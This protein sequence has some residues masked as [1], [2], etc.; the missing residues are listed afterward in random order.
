MTKT[1]AAEMLEK[2]V[3]FTDQIE[4]RCFGPILQNWTHEVGTTKAAAAEML[5]QGLIFVL[6]GLRKG[7]LPRCPGFCWRV[8]YRECFTLLTSQLW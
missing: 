4:K 5:E 2:G 8:Q 3:I 7:A 6:T 1:A